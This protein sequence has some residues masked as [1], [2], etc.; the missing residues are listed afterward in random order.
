[1]DK[2]T[3]K[4]LIIELRDKGKSFQEISEILFNDYNVSMSRQAIY[5]MYHRACAKLEHN[6][7]LEVATCDII[8]YYCL[9]LV[10]REIKDLLNVNV[11]LSEIEDIIK[12]NETYIDKIKD[13]Q[14]DIVNSLDNYNLGRIDEIL[15]YK[16][17]KPTKV[18]ID[19]LMNKHCLSLIKQ[20]SIVILSNIYNTTENKAILGFINDK[21]NLDITLKDLKS[22]N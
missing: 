2:K 17:V 19:D 12:N 1:M 8:N 16:G 20:S 6:K 7:E 13:N 22:N 10:E 9:G 3:L 11:T 5:G 4:S 14:L 15:S 18:I 21:L